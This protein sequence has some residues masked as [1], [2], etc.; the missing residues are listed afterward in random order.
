MK[1]IIIILI[2]TGIIAAGAGTAYYYFKGTDKH[3]QLIPQN[4]ML[5]GTI[6]Y[7][8]LTSKAD[9]QKLQGMEFFKDFVA[10]I[11][12]EGQKQEGDKWAEVL[13]SPLSSG[14]NLLSDIYFF[15][16]RYGGKNVMAVDIDIRDENR[17]MDFLKKVMPDSLKVSTGK[18]FKA[19]YNT[20]WGMAWN[21]HG[22]LIASMEYQGD[23]LLSKFFED[24]FNRP[25]QQSIMNNKFFREFEASKKDISLFVN[26]GEY[27]RYNYPAEIA[28]MTAP[29]SKW[30][31]E[32]YFIVNTTFENNRVHTTWDMKN[33]NGETDKINYLKDKGLPSDILG[34]ITLKETYILLSASIS[35]KK[36]LSL[37]DEIAFL[38]NGKEEF[39]MQNGLTPKDLETIFDGD[40]VFSLNDFLPAQSPANA[41]EPN[42]YY[43]ENVFPH[44]C[45]SVNFS[46]GNKAAVK[47]LLTDKMMLR[48][49]NIYTVSLDKNYTL[50]LAEN[51]TGF[52]FTDD[53]LLAKSVS[54]NKLSNVLKK[55]LS[56]NMCNYPACSY[57]D[58]NFSE[59][60]LP[61]R[62][63][64]SKMTGESFY[65]RFMTYTRILKDIRAYGK[66]SNGE[67][68]LDLTDGPG[69]SLY[70]LIA[71][72]DE[73][74]KTGRIG[75]PL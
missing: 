17:F 53:S 40:I 68:N 51:K 46:S 55:D 2:I 13:K 9:M 1:K 15:T 8:S 49:D 45:F 63:Y 20:S 74:Y 28:T 41:G 34:M 6:D 12:T 73:L 27:Y 24:C 71:Q 50:Y 44:A 58:L 65:N 70:R 64:V 11:K 25:R 31:E 18:N 69:N 21:S 32:T 7:L 26:M 75:N 59:Y 19:I 16:V 30:L 37:M 57:I 36:I 56:E 72:G 35:P 54:A 5:I 14:I 61:L 4:A 29:V 62:N 23:S 60:P 10:K 42:P 43:T 67:I 22:L 33:S 47:K 66:F 52:T 39:A 3:L 38:K 48:T